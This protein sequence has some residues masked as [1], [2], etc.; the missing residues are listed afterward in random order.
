M[1]A[2]TR[3][4]LDTDDVRDD[5]ENILGQLSERQLRLVRRLSLRGRIRWGGKIS[6]RSGR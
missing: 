5:L 2:G 4:W 1:A 3:E 6:K